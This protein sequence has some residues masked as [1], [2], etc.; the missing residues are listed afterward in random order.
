MSETIYALASARG[1]SGVAVIRVSGKHAFDSL[2]A[3]TGL[4]DIPFRTAILPQE[5]GGLLR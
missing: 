5:V 4:T 2:R 3:L 1:T